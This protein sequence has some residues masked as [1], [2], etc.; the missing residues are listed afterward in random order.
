VPREPSDHGHLSI[1]DD[2]TP[3]T[4]CSGIDPAVG[5]TSRQYAPT[6]SHLEHYEARAMDLEDLAK[7]F[8]DTEIPYVA[9]ESSARSGDEA[10]IAKALIV[11]HERLADGAGLL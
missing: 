10:L 4:A 8:V 1:G 7:G 2:H 11:I 3:L 5:D 9:Y 6:M